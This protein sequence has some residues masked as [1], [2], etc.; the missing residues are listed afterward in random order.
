MDNYVEYRLSNVKIRMRPEALPHIFTCQQG[1]K[2]IY[3]SHKKVRKRDISEKETVMYK[4]DF[5][6]QANLTEYSSKGIQVSC[7]TE[8]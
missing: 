1:T 5:C 3:Q 7:L 2:M 6:C 8:D 4:G